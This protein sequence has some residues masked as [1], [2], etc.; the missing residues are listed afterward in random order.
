MFIHLFIHNCK[1]NSSG[2]HITQLFQLIL[3]KDYG[4]DFFYFLGLINTFKKCFPNK[5]LKN[6]PFM[7]KHYQCAGLG[8]GQVRYEPYFGPY[9]WPEL[10]A[11]P[12]IRKTLPDLI[13]ISIELEMWKISCE[14][15]DLQNFNFQMKFWENIYKRIHSEFEKI[16]QRSFGPWHLIIL[17]IFQ[18]RFWN[19][20]SN[21]KASK[22]SIEMLSS[23]VL[24]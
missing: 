13:W 10:T 20:W 5:R 21:Q 1:R 18:W 3:T 17:T 23:T 2:R 11:N 14:K 7:F 19:F 24:S 22:T 9:T 16:F 15:R 8:T 6:K 4:R 12:K